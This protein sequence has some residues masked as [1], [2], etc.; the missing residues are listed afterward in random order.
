MAHPVT[1]H[2][3]N[4]RCETT[5]FTVGRKKIEVTGT[6]EQTRPISK[7]VCPACRMWGDVVRIEQE[8]AA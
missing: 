3:T 2:C 4:P 5:A 8:E 6:D 7:L 1:A